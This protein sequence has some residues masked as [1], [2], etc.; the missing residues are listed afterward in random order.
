MITNL[1]PNGLNQNTPLVLLPH[2]VKNDSLMS[3]DLKLH[4]LANVS[5]RT[6]QRL[7][8]IINKD[9]S[10]TVLKAKKASRRKGASVRLGIG[11]FHVVKAAGSAQSNHRDAN[12]AGD[13]IG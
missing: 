7:A 8:R 6:E 13:G 2:V 12:C 4:P 5:K 3:K 9:T 1:I 10:A 11:F